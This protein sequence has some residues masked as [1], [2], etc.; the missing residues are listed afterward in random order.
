MKVINLFGGPGVGK[1]TVAMRVF[2]E[3]NM[4]QIKIEYVDEYAKELTWNQSFKL[5]ENQRMIFANQH[6]KF[7]RLKDTIDMVV[8][9]APLFNS[10]VYSGKDD[11]NKTFHADVFNEFNEYKNLNFFLKRE[12]VYKEHGRSQKLE[13]AIKVDEEVLRCL[14]WFNVPYVTVGLDKAPETILSFL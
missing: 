8:T 3:L 13:D 12:T 4:K 11:K 7:F 10:I 2:T 5:M 14:K 6:Q 1:T 9:D